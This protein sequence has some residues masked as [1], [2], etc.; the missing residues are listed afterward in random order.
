MHVALGL[1][2]ALHLRARHLDTL[3][4]QKLAVEVL[5]FSSATERYELIIGAMYLGLITTGLG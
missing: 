1:L 3:L 5:K 2:L 4:T